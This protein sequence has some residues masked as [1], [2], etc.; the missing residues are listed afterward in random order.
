MASGPGNGSL[1]GPPAVV[2]DLVV[3]P[4]TTIIGLTEV[5]PHSPMTDPHP[6]GTGD[7]GGF[8]LEQVGRFESGQFDEDAA[9]IVAHSRDVDSLFVVNADIGGVDVLDV[10]SPDDRQALLMR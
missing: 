6:A 2:D 1:V 8:A 10:S 4:R 3:V 9:D 5:R 7:H